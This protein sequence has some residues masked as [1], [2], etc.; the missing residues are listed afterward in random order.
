MEFRRNIETNI[1]GKDRAITI[2]SLKSFNICNIYI[3]S[4]FQFQRRL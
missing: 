2:L 3:L 1:S 4:W